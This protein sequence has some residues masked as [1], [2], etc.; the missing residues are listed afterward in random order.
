[1][2]YIVDLILIKNLLNGNEAIL[3]RLGPIMIYI[4]TSLGTN[5]FSLLL[6]FRY[7]CA[8]TCET[9]ITLLNN[10]DYCT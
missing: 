8:K 4:G 9:V 7:L 5:A 3:I 6:T 2:E 1:M 10:E